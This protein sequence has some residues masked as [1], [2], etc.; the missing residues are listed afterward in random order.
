MDEITVEFFGVCTH[1]QRTEHLAPIPLPHRV[2]MINSDAMGTI[3]RHH[4]WVEVVRGE[5]VLHR[6][7]LDG[8][9]VSIDGAPL[10][11]VTYDEHYR[12]AIP[13]LLRDGFAQSMT[14]S[15]RVTESPDA[16]LVAGLIDLPNATFTA[17]MRPDGAA[18]AVATVQIK[19]PRRL[20]VRQFGSS[21]IVHV[22]DVP[23]GADVV[24]SN[25]ANAGEDQDTDFGLNFLIADP[26]PLFTPM[27]G[28][29]ACT[30]IPPHTRHGGQSIGP[31]CS[32]TNFP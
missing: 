16:A 1:I 18:V 19:G 23:P 21:E 30:D 32:N 27:N 6:F 10:A 15:P 4:T 28:P 11:T 8:H 25:T 22:I 31:G 13:R 29:R 5:H 17:Q 12:C 2:V 7:A 3:A 14:L 26:V 20:S 9:S 24:F